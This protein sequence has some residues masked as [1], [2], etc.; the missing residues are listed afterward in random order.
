MAGRLMRVVHMERE[1]GNSGLLAKLG[2]THHILARTS[3]KVRVSDPQR[4][5]GT[6]PDETNSR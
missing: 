5:E 6:T 1:V 4:R 3:W 2:R